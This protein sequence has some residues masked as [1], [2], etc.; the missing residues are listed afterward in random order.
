MAS[1]TALCILLTAKAV[2]T[3]AGPIPPPRTRVSRGFN[4]SDPYAN[5]PTYDQLPLDPSFP[6]KAAW[7]VWGDTDELG[8]LNH[9]NT[10]TIL[11]AKS[12]IQT[13]RVFNLNLDLAMPDP[14]LNP[15]RHPLIHDIEPQAGYQDDV[16]TLNTQ[17]STQYD[18]LRHFPYS[19][20]FSQSSYQ[21][22]NDLLTF[23]DIVAPG[24]SSTLG[25]QNAAQKGITGRG[26]LLDWAGWMESK[27]ASFD[28]FATVI[29]TTTDLDAVAEWQG[30]DPA[31]F[32][33]PGDFLVIRTGFTKQ[34]QALSVHEQDLLPFRQ[35]ADMQWVGVEASDATL[36]WLW[37]KKLS[38]VGSD[39]PTFE[40]AP[41]DEGPIESP[42]P[43]SLHQ[44]F[45][46]GWG[47]SIVE[48]LDLETLAAACHELQRYSF[49]FTLQNLN[50]V[51]GIASPPNA[52][53]IL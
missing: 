27:K 2:F 32:A 7:G 4:A 39:N 16:L 26:I 51:G 47:Q 35:G 34:Y 41:F 14:P 52:M 19:T 31:L 37:D 1:F 53:A 33:K 29:I 5:W 17:I 25:I 45:I 10:T 22:Y 50:V 42:V 8:A 18:G 23:N 13:G 21:F 49:F 6:T 48:F 38:L 40:S 30:L 36:R 12:E 3:N 46:G 15:L 9:I 43:R 24:G 28:A 11:A 44:V 20:N